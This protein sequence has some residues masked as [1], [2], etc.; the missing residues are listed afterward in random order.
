[1]PQ[2]T[3]IAM[4]GRERANASCLKVPDLRT[5]D[6]ATMLDERSAKNTYILP[7]KSAHS[8]G[9]EM[10]VVARLNAQRP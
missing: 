2:T 7:I 10:N 4:S 6:V 1:M 9:V 8:T 3:Y 5:V